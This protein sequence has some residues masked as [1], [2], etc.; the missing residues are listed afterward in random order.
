[1]ID[2]L[3]DCSM[4]NQIEVGGIGYLGYPALSALI[5]PWGSALTVSR[6]EAEGGYNG[7]LTRGGRREGLSIGEPNLRGGNRLSGVC[8]WSD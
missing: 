4:G 7:F 2:D 8:C 1:V 5:M 6:C 3:P